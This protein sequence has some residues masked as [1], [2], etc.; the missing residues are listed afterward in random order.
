MAS[1]ALMTCF[2]C[3]EVGVHI[4]CA[5]CGA[6]GEHAA[7]WLDGREA[8]C[9][10]CVLPELEPG[11]T[12]M[13]LELI[14]CPCCMEQYPAWTMVRVHQDDHWCCF[15]ALTVS[16]ALMLAEPVRQMAVL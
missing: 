9:K 11:E 10:R 1:A 2:A 13:P 16:N 14:R 4:D 5:S 8:V 15:C 3:D 7:T 12:P 6:H